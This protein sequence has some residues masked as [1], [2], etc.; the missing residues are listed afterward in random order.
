MIRFWVKH[1]TIDAKAKHQVL[2]LPQPSIKPHIMPWTMV[3]SS[4][5]DIFFLF[6]APVGGFNPAGPN[7]N[8]FLRGKANHYLTK[9]DLK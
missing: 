1:R 2:G 4:W 6:I 5:K 7:P 9:P 8:P 3:N